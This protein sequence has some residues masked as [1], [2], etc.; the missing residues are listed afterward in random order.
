MQRINTSTDPTLAGNANDWDLIADSLSNANK[1]VFVDSDLWE[2]V[3][4]LD[5]DANRPPIGS[6]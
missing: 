4:I 3:T 5:P 1:H 6:N 2:A